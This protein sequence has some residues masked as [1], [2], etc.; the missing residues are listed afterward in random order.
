MTTARP[1]REIDGKGRTLAE[2]IW[3]PAR[4]DKEAAA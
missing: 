3:S 1:S 2:R 4:L